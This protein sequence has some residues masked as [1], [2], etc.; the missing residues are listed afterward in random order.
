MNVFRDLEADGRASSA[1]VRFCMQMLKVEEFEHAKDPTDHPR[2]VLATSLGE[3]SITIP[4]VDVV[5]DL[6][7]DRTIDRYHGLWDMED[8]VASEASRKQRHG[9]VGRVK[10]G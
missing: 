3:T 9:R 5:V 4:D 8:F 7:N 10:Q 2:Q 6:G 1:I